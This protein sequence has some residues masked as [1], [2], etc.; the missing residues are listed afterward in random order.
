MTQGTVGM[1][2]DSS[3]RV[4]LVPTTLTPNVSGAGEELI[5]DVAADRDHAIQPAATFEL[6]EPENGGVNRRPVRGAT[7]RPWLTLSFVCH[8]NR[9]TCATSAF[10]DTRVTLEGFVFAIAIRAQLA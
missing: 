2:R 7:D 6:A 8:N 4:V 1:L 10:N 3:H 5:E 9:V